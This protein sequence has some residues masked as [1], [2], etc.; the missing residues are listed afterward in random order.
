MHLSHCWIG[1]LLK[2]EEEKKLQKFLDL[3]LFHSL[4]CI[5]YRAFWK[6]LVGSPVSAITQGDLGYVGSMQ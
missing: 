1:V 3:L 5:V 4:S 2:K 6:R